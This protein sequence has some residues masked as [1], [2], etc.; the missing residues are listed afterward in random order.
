MFSLNNI[1]NL[2]QGITV[3]KDRQ[4]SIYKWQIKKWDVIIGEAFTKSKKSSMIELKM[5]R[6]VSK[7]GKGLMSVLLREILSDAKKQR[8]NV[9]IEVKPFNDPNRPF[10]SVTQARKRVYHWYKNFGFEI[11]GENG[12][13]RN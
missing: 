10:E 1:S 2:F 3:T 11:N 8:K 5:I 12:I 7:N 4:Q 9:E 6:R 13:Y